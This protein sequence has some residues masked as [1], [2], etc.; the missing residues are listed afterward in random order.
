MIYRSRITSINR[1]SG[2][3][4]KY[5]GGFQEHGPLVHGNLEIGLENERVVS[6]GVAISLHVSPRPRILQC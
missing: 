3:C 2:D 4:P 5:R 1:F 6:F